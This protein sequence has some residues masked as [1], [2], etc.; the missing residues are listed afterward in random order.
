M[1]VTTSP[2]AFTDVP[3]T[4]GSISTAHPSELGVYV[5]R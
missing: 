5:P 3:P 4:Y 1:S 2:T